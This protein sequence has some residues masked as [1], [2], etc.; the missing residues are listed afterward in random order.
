MKQLLTLACIIAMLTFA[1]QASAVPLISFN[2]LAQT[3]YQGGSSAI[4]VN[5]TLG[6]GEMLDGYGLNF[7][8]DPALLALD[9]TS[10]VTFGSSLAG[11]LNFYSFDPVAGTFNL[12]GIDI[13]ANPIANGTFLL[14]TLV[15]SGTGVGASAV[16]LLGT[17]SYLLSSSM[18]E[19]N[20]TPAGSYV[21]VE[22][23]PEPGTLLLLGAGL[24]VGYFVR[25]RAV[26]S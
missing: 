20:F 7:S 9:P 16:D 26:G 13:S 22:P 19:G 18:F 10:G 2:P 25:R 11:Y 17:S 21:T 4:D 6:A 1:G 23:V 12:A 14:A 24:A 5:L 8:F 15:F 3:I